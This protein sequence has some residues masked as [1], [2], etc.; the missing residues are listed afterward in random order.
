MIAVREVLEH[1]D[2]KVTRTHTISAGE[3]PIT[4]ALR[5]KFRQI[6]TSDN[7]PED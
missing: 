3:G 7:V 6:V 4:N 2:L 1:E 5:T